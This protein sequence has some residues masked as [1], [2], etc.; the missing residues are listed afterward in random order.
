MIMP[1]CINSVH[2]MH[3]IAQI[4]TKASLIDSTVIH[5][6]QD[7]LTWCTAAGCFYCRT[8]PWQLFSDA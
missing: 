3:C 4:K 5:C 1:D 7:I 6:L 2:K 8:V